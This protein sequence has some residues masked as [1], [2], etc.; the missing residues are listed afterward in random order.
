MFVAVIRIIRLQGEWE[1][2]WKQQE[3]GVTA[4]GLQSVVIRK[5]ASTLLW[6]LLTRAQLGAH[7][8]SLKYKC[9]KV[10]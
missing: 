2:S 9:I 1:R 7:L 8:K 6:F 10:H 4:R 3:R 5:A